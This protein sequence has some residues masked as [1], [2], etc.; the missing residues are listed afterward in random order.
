MSLV[1]GFAGA[2]AVTL[3]ATLC[4]RVPLMKWLA[5][6]GQHSIVV[7][8]G[9]VIPLGVMRMFIARLSGLFDPGTIALLAT[10]GSIGGAVLLYLAVR[11]TPL[12][13]LFTRPGWA[14]IGDATHAARSVS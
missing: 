5:W 2:V 4:M 7:Y 1:L 6:L 9:F 8:L 11:A 14:Q 13:Y 12:R 10:L 3:A